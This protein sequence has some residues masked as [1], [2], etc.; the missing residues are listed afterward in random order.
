MSPS[1]REATWGVVF[2]APW[3]IGFLAFTIGPLIA[4]LVLSFTDFD[5][6]RP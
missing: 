1:R 2:V 4:S 6:V 3:I 5:L